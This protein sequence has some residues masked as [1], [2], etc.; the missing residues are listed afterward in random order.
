MSA[1]FRG[2]LTYFWNTVYQT[3]RATE[4]IFP[5]WNT[6]FITAND[7]LISKTKSFF[8]RIT[9]KKKMFSHPAFAKAIYMSY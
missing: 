2:A 6:Y 3:Y 7:D 9:E 1:Y 4:K 5:A 8:V